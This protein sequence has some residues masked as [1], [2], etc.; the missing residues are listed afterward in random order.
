M[1]ERKVD[2]T[3]LNTVW[4]FLQTTCYEMRHLIDRTAQNYLIGQLHDLSVGVWT[5]KGE[6]VAAPI[7]LPLQ[8]LGS[9]FAIKDILK[10]YE[11]SLEPGDVI[12]TNDPYHGGH[13]CHLPD[14]GFF[15]PVFYKGELLFMSLA[16]AHQQDTGGSF[17]GGYFP[18][19]YDIHAEGLCIP[20]TKVWAAGKERTDVMELIWNN[21]RFPNG[22]RVDNASMIAATKLAE[23]RLIGLLDRYGKDTVLACIQEM[24][25]R[26]ERAVR[27]EI[28]KIPDGTYSA[29]AATDDD[30]TE[31]D[32]P[33]WVRVD[34]TV[35]GDEIIMDFSRSD[36]QRKG[37][38]NSIYASTYANALAAVCITMDPALADYQNEGTHRAVKVIAPE[39]LVVNCRYPATVGASPV[40]VGCQVMEAVL[41]ALSKAR[42][43]RSVA[44]WGKHRGDYVFAV[45]PRTNERYVR[46]SFDYDGS[47]GAEWGYDGYQG[48]SALTA[49][50][51][52]NR[53]NVEEEEV[54]IPWRIIKWEYYPDLT[55]AGRWRGGPGVHW[56]AVHYGLEAQ[57]AT[58]SSDGDE[59]LGFGA[60]GGEPSPP[61]RTYV[62]SGDEMI[63]LKPHRLVHM[64][65]GDVVIKYSSGGGGVGPAW[66]RD[67]EAVRLDVKK[68]LVSL[69]AARDTYKVALAPNTLEIDQE[70]T[71]E[72]R[73]PMENR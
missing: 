38:V 8:M 56:E 22:V 20:P 12:L 7:G 46:T 52:I 54:R 58:G 71:K 73:A 19:A 50:G 30:G 63:R 55:G 27:A 18:N 37:F 10:K 9:Q 69:E 72:L 41:E 2:P 59:M 62:K 24:F 29:E 51:A 49:L 53:G 32:V 14:W 60:L 42:P 15:R 6:T 4:H 68:G 11:G 34:L 65:E 48:L 17:P 33:V 21:V 28:A 23:Q 61:C 39:G 13:N 44:A 45:D 47:G 67:P 5:A 31:L 66:Q 35:K 16:R 25:D 1:A 26:T 64:K 3:T 43:D 70:K 57:N 40:N 36:G